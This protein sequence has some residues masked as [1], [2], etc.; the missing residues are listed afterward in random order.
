M[1]FFQEEFRNKGALK[2]HFSVIRHTG[3]SLTETHHTAKVQEGQIDIVHRRN[4]KMSAYSNQ[5]SQVS[6]LH[7]S[8]I[9]NSFFCSV[10]ESEVRHPPSGISDCFKWYVL[11]VFEKRVNNTH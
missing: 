3:M 8:K 6:C 10:F 9:Y 5:E 1:P 11:S 4:K 2:S 7:F